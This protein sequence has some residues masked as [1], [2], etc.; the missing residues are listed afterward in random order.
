MVILKKGVTKQAL[1][2]RLRMI[3]SG[4]GVDVW[5]AEFV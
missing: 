2:E 5:D 3:F 4:T 1:R